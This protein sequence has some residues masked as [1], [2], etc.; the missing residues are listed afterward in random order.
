MKLAV[1]SLIAFVDQLEGVTTKAVHVTMPVRCAPV[2]EQNTHLMG[3][4]G[5]Q[6]DE[7]PEHVRILEHQGGR[8]N[9]WFNT[10]T[11]LCS[12]SV[13]YVSFHQNTHLIN[14]KNFTYVIFYSYLLHKFSLSKNTY[15]TRPDLVERGASSNVYVCI[16]T[17]EQ[18]YKRRINQRKSARYHLITSIEDKLVKHTFLTVI[19]YKILFYTSLIKTICL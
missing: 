12:L 6:G 8:L 13:S 16:C 17:L 2:R 18:F 19:M 11:S 9:G 5:S 15:T 3:R 10:Q 14:I 7:I 1:E 4:L